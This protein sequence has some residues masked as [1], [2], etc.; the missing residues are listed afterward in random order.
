MFKQPKINFHGK[1]VILA[2]DNLDVDGTAILK[3][4][5]HMVEFDI[6]IGPDGGQYVHLDGEALDMDAFLEGELV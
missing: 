1:E 5:G 6:V 4:D 3:I 2:V